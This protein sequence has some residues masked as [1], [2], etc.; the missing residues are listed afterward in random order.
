MPE[1][2]TPEIFR[3]LFSAQPFD[4]AAIDRVA[5]YYADD[6]VFI[7]PIQTVRGREEFLEMNKRLIRRAKS[8]RFDVHTLTGDD[9]S[10]FATWTMHL[11]M[12][13]PAPTMTIDG[14]THCTLRDG[15]ITQ[16]R[17]YWDLL[18]AAMNTIPLA[19]PVYRALVAKLG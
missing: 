17:D 2:I 15:R 10:L 18:G 14:V 13:G 9:A 12:R 19:G 1:P 11:A 16:H 7:D 5:P 4:A 6:V 8:L 3:A